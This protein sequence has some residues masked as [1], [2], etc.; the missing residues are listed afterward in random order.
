VQVFPRTSLKLS[1]THGLAVLY[2]G[3]RYQIGVR[4]VVN[5]PYGRTFLP[6]R[7]SERESEARLSVNPLLFHRGGS[8][9]Q[10]RV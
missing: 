10:W 2:W 3:L 8:I 9:I 5:D 6:F 4:W 7:L 1:S